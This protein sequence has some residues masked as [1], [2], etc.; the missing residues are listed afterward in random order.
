MSDPSPDA[1]PRP[2]Q[3]KYSCPHCGGALDLGAI[4]SQST[5]TMA[6]PPPTTQVPLPAAQL[7]STWLDRV[8]PIASALGRSQPGANAPSRSRR[9]GP[10]WIGWVTLLAPLLLLA[11]WLLGRIVFEIS[12]PA[13]SATLPT[14]T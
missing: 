5:A 1:I 9:A 13:A 12:P 11:L 6:P 10:R 14:L 7:L 3:A 4:A 8:F 2:P